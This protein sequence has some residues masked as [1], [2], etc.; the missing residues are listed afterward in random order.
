ME[1]KK[2]VHRK[3]DESFKREAVQLSLRGDKTERVIASDLG[4]HANLLN[5]WKRIYLAKGTSSFP[6][7]GHVGEQEAENRKLR[8]QLRDVTEERDIL[9]KATAIFSRMSR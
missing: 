4:I 9:K 3:Y 1:G 8:K 7:K 5:R 2:R 6:G